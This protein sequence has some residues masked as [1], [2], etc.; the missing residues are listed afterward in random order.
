MKID[1]ARKFL[2]ANQSP[3]GGKCGSSSLLHNL[4]DPWVLFIPSSSMKYCFADFYLYV[5]YYVYWFVFDLIPLD[6][7]LDIY[8]Y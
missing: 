1:R 6:N 5:D 4:D 2:N 7:S 8:P 3:W